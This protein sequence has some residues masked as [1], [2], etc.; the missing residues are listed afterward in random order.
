[1][2]PGGRGQGGWWR[3]LSEQAAQAA[4]VVIMPNGCPC[5]VENP[6]RRYE[7]FENYSQ[8]NLGGGHDLMRSCSPESPQ[9][10]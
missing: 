5:C 10:F 3:L 6:G 4:S 2:L 8:A 1:M 7:S 9:P